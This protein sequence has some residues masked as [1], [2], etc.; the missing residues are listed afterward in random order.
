MLLAFIIIVIAI[1]ILVAIWSRRKSGE[2]DP[3]AS[4]KS[5]DAKQSAS[6]KTNASAVTKTNSPSAAKS[7]ASNVG[8]RSVTPN[9]LA[10]RIRY[11]IDFG[12][13]NSSA[14][15]REHPLAL[16][17]LDMNKQGSKDTLL[18]VGVAAGVILQDIA[19]SGMAHGIMG[20]V[21]RGNKEVIGKLRQKV[22]G[23]NRIIKEADM[24]YGEFLKQFDC[25]TY[26]EVAGLQRVCTVKLAK[27]GVMDA[28][29]KQHLQ[30]DY[31]GLLDALEK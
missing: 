12:L 19:P 14:A 6:S 2:A 4:E 28:G 15:Y 16:S 24:S 27:A 31:D 1:L 7:N 8:R 18:A 23:L 13:K 25:S 10:F 29:P 26:G 3:A 5:V 9:A 21:L 20:E 22:S 17:K 11:E 30:D